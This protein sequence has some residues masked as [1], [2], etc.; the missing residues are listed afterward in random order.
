MADMTDE[1]AALDEKLARLDVILEEMR[2][3]VVAFSGGVDSTFLAAAAHRVLGDKALAVTAVSASSAE[4]EL[5]KARGLAEQIGIRLE[6]VHTDEMADPNYVR[7]APD[8]CYHCKAALA[9]K[10]E[11]VARRYGDRYPCLVYGAIADDAGDYRPGMSAAEERGVRAPIKEAGMTKAEVRALSR[12]W[13]L[14]TWN[15]PASAC[16]SSRIPYGIPVT[17]EA[18]Q[19]VDRSEAFLK[20]LGFRQVRVRHHQDIA[21]IEVPAEDMARFFE[22]GTDMRAVEKLKEIYK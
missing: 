4:G 6:V 21:R 8:R 5:E 17:G 14:P 10:L 7:N 19:M 12:R 18:L 1:A 9:G 22:N 11:E 13:G 2:G 20:T 16:L 15:Q 3:V